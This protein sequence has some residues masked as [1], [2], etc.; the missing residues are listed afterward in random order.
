MY[1]RYT[2]GVAGN[3]FENSEN[4]KTAFTELL[5]KG[6]AKPSLSPAPFFCSEMQERFYETETAHQKFCASITV[7]RIEHVGKPLRRLGAVLSNKPGGLNWSTQ[8]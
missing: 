1:Q 3:F 4:E 8:H 6:T 7:Y 2:A 5:R